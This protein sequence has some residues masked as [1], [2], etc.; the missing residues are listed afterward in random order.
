MAR[1]YPKLEYHIVYDDFRQ[2]V[3]N[4]LSFMGIYRGDI[5][6]PIPSVLPKICFHLVFSRVRHGDKFTLLFLD[7]KDKELTKLE[8]ESFDLPKKKPP[9][10]V[11]VD[12]VISGV[13]ISEEGNHR[14]VIAFGEEEEAKQDLIIKFK[15]P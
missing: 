4:K 1:R 2:E 11:L 14:I 13:K 3:G 8:S 10:L 9:R 5:I 6:L 7:P 15:N 12:V